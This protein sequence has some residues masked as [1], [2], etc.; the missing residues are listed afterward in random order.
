MDGHAVTRYAAAVSVSEIRQRLA[1]NLARVESLVAATSAIDSSPTSGPLKTDMLRAAVVFLH[2]TLEDVLRS[3]LALELPRASPERL[4]H[5]PII[6]KDDRGKT[7]KPESISLAG[8][9]KYR[10]KTIDEVIAEI[11]TE[12][13]D[14]S[15]FNNIEDIGSAVQRMDLGNLSTLG[16]DHHATTLMALTSRR[17][18]IVHR[19]DLNPYA[20]LPG[21][22]KTQKIHSST[23]RKWKDCV[24]AV[25]VAILDALEH[26][27]C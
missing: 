20:S 15:N 16:L 23:V 24:N 7:R 26:K 17:H 10:G 4:E 27:S 5:I 8:L 9:S 3:G 14:R 13:L 11:V 2:A 18:W 1:S 12:Y 21:Q 22:S 6:V 25:C 19:V